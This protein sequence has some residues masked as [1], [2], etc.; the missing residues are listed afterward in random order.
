MENR[1]IR[2]I[3]NRKFTIQ[4]QNIFRFIALDKRSAAIDF[5]HD[6]DAKFQLLKTQ[7]MMGRVSLYASD[8]KV[9]DLIHNGYTIVYEIKDE[10]TICILEIFKWQEK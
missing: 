6:I 9:R 10:Q 1:V 8:E 3:R 4:L 7:P 5:Q 2:L